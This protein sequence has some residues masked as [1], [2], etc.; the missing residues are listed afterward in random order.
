MLRPATPLTILLLVAFVL[1]LLSVIS[2]PVVKGIPL[3]T[4]QGVNFGVFGYCQGSKCSGIRVGYTTSKFIGHRLNHADIVRWSVRQHQRR[5]RLQPSVQRQ[6]FSLLPIDRAS[7]RSIPQPCL[8][9]FGWR[10]S[11]SLP[12]ALTAVPTRP[13]D[14]ATTH[15]ARHFAS[16]PGGRPTIRATLS[17]GR[18]DRPGIDHSYHCRGRCHLCNA[19]DTRQSQSKEEEDRRERRDEWRELLQSS[20]LHTQSRVTT[21]DDGAATNG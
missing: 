3:A 4:F 6:T 9:R 13:L 15:I 12:L 8:S 17:V 18:M 1:L 14:T 19:T 2:T 5:C 11:P 10:R 16:L 20:K 21:S 7:C